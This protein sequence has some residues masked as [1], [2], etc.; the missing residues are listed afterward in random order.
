MVAT[1]NEPMEFDEFAEL[2]EFNEY[3]VP[4]VLTATRIKQHQADVPASVTILDAALIKMLG[5]QSLADL[6][7]YV[8][9][10]M[11]GP[12]KNNN[13][14]AVHYHGGQAALPKNLQVLID[15]RSMYRTGVAAVN[16]FEMPIAINDIRRIEI[17]RGPNAASYGANSYQAVINILSKHPADTSGTAAEILT[18]NN[19]EEDLYL[20]HGGTHNGTD[21]RLSVTQKNNAGFEYES[22]DRRSR[23]LTLNTFKQMDSGAELESSFV[24]LH[25]QKEIKDTIKFQTNTNELSE[26]RFEL[27]FRFTQDLSTKHQLQVKSYLTQYNQ[28]QA[29][30]VAGVP[31]AFLDDNLRALY[32]LN[33]DAANAITEGQDPS[34]LLTSQAEVDLATLILTAYPG[35]TGL[36]PVTGTINAD[37]DEYRFDIELQ[38]TYVYSE[39]L[40]VVSGASFRRDHVTSQTYFS[41][42]L[43]SD[44]SRA[45]GSI[46]WQPVDD[47]HLH[48][49]AMAEKETGMDF[50]FAP[51][52]AINYKLTPAQSLRLVYSEAVRSPD[53]FEQDG[54]WSFTVD[55]PQI[56]GQSALNGNT[57][58]Q[59][60][61][62]PGDLDHQFI[63]SYELGYYG[64]L[65]FAEIEL[66]VR[67]FE[68]HLSDVIYQSL[69]ISGFETDDNICLKFDGIEWQLSFRPWNDGKIRWV[70]AYL[71]A[72]S[73]VVIINDEKALLRIYYQKTSALSWLQ[74]WPNRFS[75]HVSY[76]VADA[77][78]DN[79]EKR[80]DPYRFERI[81]ARL[82]KSLSLQGYDVE[83][84]VTAQHDLS[85][86]PYTLSGNLYEDKSRI[87]FS[88]ALNF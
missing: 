44:T 27:G 24:L 31:V 75:S 65:N 23:F 77:L 13:A 80:F 8:P 33:K 71:N 56:S 43:S 9:G 14:D 76:L 6:L 3:S 61:Q 17:V 46:S 49:A 1:A 22:D 55:D 12:D 64:R 21:Y 38:D 50:V 84:N 29:I 35:A 47:V 39:N 67:L 26:E 11:V 45:F 85:T 5:V 4:L 88:L 37:M 16:W 15:G 72:H 58:Y 83:L 10:M 57:F 82:A 2:P 81:E 51:R 32:V 54:Y 59:T 74:T 18:G 40:T 36:E 52:A 70:G 63:T 62:G 79:N 73:D 78:D 86:E 25:A 48:V 66:D 69:K 19:G 34:T 41:E 30:N 68:E 60:A 53:L 7:R 28:R 20:R 42:S 87:Q